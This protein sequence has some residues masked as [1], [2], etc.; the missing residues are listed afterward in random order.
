MSNVRRLP[1]LRR[2]KR[3]LELPMSKLSA[4]LLK[5]L[6]VF[7][8]CAFALNP[9]NALEIEGIDKSA[10]IGSLLTGDT[11]LDIYER[12]EALRKEVWVAMPLGI[13]NATFVNE[14]ASGFQAFD[15]RPSSTFSQDDTIN[16]YFE[17][18][19]FGQR[20]TADGSEVE[21]NVD[22]TI[23]NESGQR[24]INQTD[25]A[26]VGQVTPAATYEFAANISLAIASFPAGTYTLSLTVR[27]AVSSKVG[28]I[29]LAFDVEANPQDDN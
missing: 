17:P 1:R 20:T 9:A 21:L 10:T 24:L 27:D 28:T 8:C 6:F 12:I 13:A 25:F 5:G 29:V 18:I 3:V 7:G 26:S 2:G 14:P 23:E 19:G 16:I 4:V 11:P 15:A 22:I